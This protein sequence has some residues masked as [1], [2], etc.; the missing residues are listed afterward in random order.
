MGWQKDAKELRKRSSEF[1]QNLCLAQPSCGEWG[2]GRLDGRPEHPDLSHAAA[3]RS[4]DP[5]TACDGNRLG[6]AEL[7]AWS[8]HIHDGMIVCK[9]HQDMED[10]LPRHFASFFLTLSGLKI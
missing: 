7:N 10:G 2:V 8:W 1:L 9:D 6:W 3:S 4:L 5:G